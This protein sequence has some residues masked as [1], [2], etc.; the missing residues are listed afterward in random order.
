MTWR[1]FIIGIVGVLGISLLTPY[2][3]YVVGNTYLTGSHF[4]V[5]AFFLLLVLA[6]VVNVAIKL[7]RTRWALRQAELM[8][9][10]S[11]LLVS[12]TVPASGLMRYLF[13]LTTSPPY[14][15]QRSDIPWGSDVLPAAPAGVLLSNSRHSDAVDK[16]FEGARGEKVRVPW[17]QWSAVLLTWGVFVAFYYAGTFF[18]GGILRRQ[19][20]D[21][22]RLL[23][24]LARFPLELTAGSDERGLLPHVFRNGSFLVGVA[25]SV[26][27]GLIR[28]SPLFTGEQTGMSVFLPLRSILAGTAL[29]Q[30]GI[31]DSYVYPIAI[32]FAFLVSREVSLSMWLFYL[33]FCVQRQV[34][35]SWAIPVQGGAYPFGQWQQAG[36]FIAFTAWLFWTSRHHLWGVTRRALGLPGGALDDDEPIPYR[37]AF[38]GLVVCTVG[39]T[40]WFVRLGVAPWVACLVMGLMLTLV[41][42]HARLIAQGGVIL[43]GQAWMPGEIL[44]GAFGGG[45]FSGAGAV[46]VQAQGA[47]ILADAREMLSPHAMNALRIASVFERGRRYFLPAMLA[48]LAVALA[49][50]GYSSLHWVYYKEGALNLANTY[51]ISWHSLRA[52][53]AA[54]SMIA[55]PNATQ[56]HCVGLF[57]GLGLMVLLLGL[58]QAF[59]WWPINPL[60]ILLAASWAITPLYFNFF[61]GWL[62]K[63]LV[64]RF[65]SGPTLRSVRSFFIGVIA[66]EAA[67]VG[68]GTF[69]SLLTGIRIGYVF[70]PS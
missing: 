3:D 20:V 60:G 39:M 40:W 7:L 44:Q 2:N 36:A 32:G 9:V 69:F 6:L 61:L 8:L 5:G 24:P 58:R 38:W 63:T 34:I 51:A 55:T 68:L 35:Y 65:G 17:R 56:P 48:A 19:W 11:M 12:A 37:V 14:L 52:Y 59:Y 27:F 21:H 26:A 25:V 66:A 64:L 43:T 45:I 33:L 50:A 29:A 67:Q 15:S 1:A 28:L 70:M 10:F 18:L 13:P 16:F 46:V 4:P 31:S 62:V 41:V 22:E 54:H 49:A 30:M 47:I 23:F 53:N 42:V 57:S